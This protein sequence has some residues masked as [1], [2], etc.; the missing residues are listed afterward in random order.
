MENSMTA[1]G[2]GYGILAVAYTIGAI[3]YLILLFNRRQAPTSYRNFLIVHKRS[4]ERPKV[5]SVTKQ[6]PSRSTVTTPATPRSPGAA[7]KSSATRAAVSRSISTAWGNVGCISISPRS[8]RS[9]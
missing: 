3:G 6:A 8:I 9:A 1:I 2:L 7:A 4:I 5:L